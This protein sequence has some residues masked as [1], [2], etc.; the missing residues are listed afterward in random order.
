MCKDVIFLQITYEIKP[1]SEDHKKFSIDRESGV[2]RALASFDRELKNE[3]YITVVALDGAPSNRSNHQPP[4]TPN[5]GLLTGFLPVKD[6]ILYH[7]LSLS[8]Q[9]FVPILCRF[10]YFQCLRDAI[11]LM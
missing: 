10:L 11:I 2:I 9:N 6:D 5:Q 8:H 1:V 4:G 3:Y 7:I